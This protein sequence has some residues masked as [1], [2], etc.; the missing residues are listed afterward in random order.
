LI[1]LIES[2]ALQIKRGQLTVIPTVNVCGTQLGVRYQPH[3]WMLM[4]NHDIN[5]NYPR[6]SS[7]NGNCFLSDAVSKLAQQ[8]DVVIDLHEGWGFNLVD[9]SS[10]GSGIFP[11]E[12]L[13]SQYLAQQMSK[14]INDGLE[15]PAIEESSNP[16]KV[17]RMKPQ[18]FMFQVLPDW[19][20]VPGTLRWWCDQNKIHY[21]LVET[22]GQKNIVALRNRADQQMTAVM[23]VLKQLKMI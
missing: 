15:I 14:E 3:Q 13:F 1:G 23:S 6:R 18:D 8:H 11:G 21:V 2:G 12:T 5:R 22:T 9:E 20:D 16:S 7:E 10:M 17:Q 19:P 4:K